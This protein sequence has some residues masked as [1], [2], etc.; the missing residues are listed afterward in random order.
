MARHPPGPGT[1]PARRAMRSGPATYRRANRRRLPPPPAGHQGPRHQA[2]DRA[3]PVERPPTA[4]EPLPHVPLE[5]SVQSHLEPGRVALGPA[6]PVHGGHL[7]AQADAPAPVEGAPL[8]ILV[9]A[10]EEE[11]LVEQPHIGQRAP[12]QEEHRPAQEVPLGIQAATA[13]R[14]PRPMHPSACAR[15]N[16]RG[17]GASEPGG[18]GAVP[19]TR[20]QVGSAARRGASRA[21]RR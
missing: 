4:P 17:W 6:R 10:V 21:R 8:P 1:T 11:A 14:S 16:G 20:R 7:R 9:F 2:E 19:R 5:R 13:G 12:A 15:A 18:A 3:G